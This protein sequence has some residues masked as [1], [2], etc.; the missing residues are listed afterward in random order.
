MRRKLKEIVN[1]EK[2]IIRDCRNCHF[3][4]L[5]SKLLFGET[6][7]C[8]IR[9]TYIDYPIINATFCTNYE[10]DNTK[11]KENHVKEMKSNKILK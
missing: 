7:R 10:D 1:G 8:L 5:D 4:K 11:C 3:N 2:P 9:K 6:C